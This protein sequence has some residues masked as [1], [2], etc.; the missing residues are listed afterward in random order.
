MAKE[1]IT[2]EQAQTALLE[3]A[4]RVK[5]SDIQKLL[6]R[7][8]E[9]DDKI[10]GVPSSFEKM[11]NQIGL[12]F[13]MIV[14]FWEEEYREIPWFSIAMA[15]GALVYFLSPID[16]IPD[17]IPIIGYV[18]DAAVILMAVKAIQSDLKAYCHFKGYD[19]EK[20]F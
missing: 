20:Y 4:K 13:E 19:L 10:K 17:F 7:K 8:D 6:D 18:D 15:V 3:N 16:L 9:L 12:L 2:E 5:E 14:D 11:I 1:S